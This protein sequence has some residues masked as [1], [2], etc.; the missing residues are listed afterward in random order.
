MSYKADAALIGLDY[1]GPLTSIPVNDPASCVVEDSDGDTTRVKSILD[2][3]N[4]EHNSGNIVGHICNLSNYTSIM[5]NVANKIISQLNKQFALTPDYQ[6][7]EIVASSLEVKVNNNVV[8]N[9]NF[10]PA[11]LLIIFNTAPALNDQVTGKIF[12]SKL[13]YHLSQAAQPNTIVV[14]K[15]DANGDETLMNNSSWNYNATTNSV[16]FV[17]AGAAPQVSEV[18]RVR[19]NLLGAGEI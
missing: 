1:I 15:V 6:Y 3:M 19:Y 5:S 7:D 10:I 13:K 12:G 8:T 16:E 14:S 18:F 11:Q 17:S 2:K 9:Y 4:F